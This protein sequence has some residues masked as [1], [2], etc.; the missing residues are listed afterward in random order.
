MALLRRRS[1]GPGVGMRKGGERLPLGLALGNVQSWQ[2]TAPRVRATGGILS[3]RLSTGRLRSSLG[4]S[5]KVP[6]ME[7][8]LG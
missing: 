7:E 2:V 5:G 4:P 3:P 8:C 6:G 1:W